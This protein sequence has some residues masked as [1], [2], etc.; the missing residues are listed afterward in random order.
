MKAALVRLG[1][2]AAIYIVGRAIYAVMA[3]VGFPSLVTMA[4]MLMFGF[5]CGVV[6]AQWDLQYRRRQHERRA[7][8]DW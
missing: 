3:S 7:A 6:A 1:V 8:D 4:V 5:A 2:C